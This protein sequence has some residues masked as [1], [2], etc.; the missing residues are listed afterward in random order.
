MPNV[1]TRGW[2][3][4]PAD[5]WCSVPSS[6]K[7]ASSSYMTTPWQAVVF[8]DAGQ[9]LAQPHGLGFFIRARQAPPGPLHGEAE[10]MQQPRQMEV[11]VPDAKALRD[12]VAATLVASRLSVREALA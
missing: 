4:T 6:Q 12:Q 10:F 3:P 8:F 11:V 2:T 9:L 7:L 5:V 1:S